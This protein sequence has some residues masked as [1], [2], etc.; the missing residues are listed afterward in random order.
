TRRQG[1]RA[2]ARVCLASVRSRSAQ[3][4]VPEPPVS[5]PAAAA[6]EEPDATPALDDRSDAPRA[7][8]PRAHAGGD[9]MRIWIDLPISLHAPLFRPIAA[10]LEELG[11][12]VVVTARDNAQTV[13]LARPRF[14]ELAVIGE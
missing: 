14:P 6:L 11:H 3:D 5:L 12:E 4:V 8:P 1:R 10:R 7:R 2:P 13:E 9:V